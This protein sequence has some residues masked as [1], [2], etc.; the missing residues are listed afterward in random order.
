MSDDKDIMRQERKMYAQGNNLSRT[1]FMCYLD[2]KLTLFRSYVG[3][4]YTA[5]LWV[6]YSNTTMNKLYIAYHNMM[7]LLIGV[8]KFEHNRPI[9]V[10]LNVPYCP[11][12][13]R[14]IVYK[15]MGRLMKS[16]NNYIK[17]ICEMS[18][19][20][21]SQIWRHWRSLLYVNGVG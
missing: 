4:L 13:I 10:Y 2:V 6:K 21:T 9:C 3:S 17:A 8:S 1:F 16:S 5:Q 15:F 14:S 20:Y 18:W 11:A 19:F 12:L 7:K